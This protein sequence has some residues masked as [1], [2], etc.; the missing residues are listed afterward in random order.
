MM[1]KKLA[2]RYTR[3]QLNITRPLFF[4]GALFLFVSCQSRSEK[5]YAAAYEKINQNQFSEAIQLLESSA[6]LEKDN[7]KKTKAQFEAARLLRFELQDYEKALNILRTIVL[8]SQD[9]K[10]RLLSQ[11]S[12]CEIYFDHLQNYPEALKELLTLEPLLPETKKKETIRLKIAQAQR[13]SGNNQAALEY[14]DVALKTST[15][16][17]NSF[18]KLKAQIFQSLQK[19]DEALKIYE[20]I[21]RKDQK[22]FIDELLFAAVSSIH[23]EKNDYKAAIEYLEKNSDHINDK[24]YLELRIKKMR[25][26]QSNKPFSRGVRK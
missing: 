20:E 8:E 17:T 13:F 1:K 2:K 22:Y 18:M 23:E 19:Q 6:D 5:L 25:E 3:L 10:M 24:N 16:E 4:V 12:I 11:E 15:A 26:K 14:V 21:F 9:S 7:I